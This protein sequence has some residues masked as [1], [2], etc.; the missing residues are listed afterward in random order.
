M[1]C[2]NCNRSTISNGKLICGISGSE[3]SSTG[4]CG[5]YEK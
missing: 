2:S 3:V 5:V 4:Y 1:N